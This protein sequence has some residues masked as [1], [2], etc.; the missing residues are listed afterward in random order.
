LQFTRTI[1]NYQKAYRKK[2]EGL[3]TELRAVRNTNESLRRQVRGLKGI[4]RVHVPSV[5]LGVAAGVLIKAHW[6]AIRQ[7]LT[8]RRSA[9]SGQATA[10]GQAGGHSSQA[11][12][13]AD[14]E[15]AVAS[16][17]P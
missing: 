5:A 11:A 8:N 2:V 15:A 9:S 16:A 10:V 1:Q 3:K 14:Q 7:W 12:T 13:N 17:A 4:L 6:K